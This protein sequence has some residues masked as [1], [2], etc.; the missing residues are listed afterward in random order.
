MLTLSFHESHN[1]ALVPGRYDIESSI[2]S[3]DWSRRLRS[4]ASEI[5]ICNLKQK[6]PKDLIYSLGNQKNKANLVNFVFKIWATNFQQ[7][8]RE[9]QIIYMANNYKTVDK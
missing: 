6:T 7:G 4:I 1:I 8:L 5:Y 9:N 2:K 3:V